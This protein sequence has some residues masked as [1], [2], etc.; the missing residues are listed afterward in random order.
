MRSPH[1]SFWAI[2]VVTLL[3]N[4]AGCINFTMQLN[5][6]SLASMPE[7]VRALVASRPLWATVGFA[8]AV[9]GGAIGGIVLLL[10]NFAARYLFGLSAIGACVTLLHLLILADTG[11]DST[12][13]FIGNL[14]QLI[15]SLFLLGYAEWAQRRSWIA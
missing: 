5:A 6:A 9:F 8:A 12:A 1:W 2:A 14:S 15:V 10:R 4:V 3:F 11:A 7:P 13:F